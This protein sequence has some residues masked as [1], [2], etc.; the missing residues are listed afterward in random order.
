MSFPH[1]Q[2]HI[3]LTYSV[4]Q[5]HIKF[6]LSRRIKDVSTHSRYSRVD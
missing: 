6:T 1:P 3:V 4:Q 5:E 2:D